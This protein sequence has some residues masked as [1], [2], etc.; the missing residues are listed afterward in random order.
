MTA[1]RIV[2]SAAALCALLACIFAVVE[3]VQ[4]RPVTFVL[5]HHETGAPSSDA[6][7]L[8]GLKSIGQVVL[9]T[10]TIKEIVPLVHDK[11]TGISIGASHATVVG[12]FKEVYCRVYGGY[13]CD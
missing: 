2:I 8:S 6:P 9:N 4:A 3:E 7:K 1:V 11:C 13:G 10:D 12:S 5:C